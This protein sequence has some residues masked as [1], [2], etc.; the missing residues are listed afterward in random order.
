PRKSVSDCKSEGS[1]G[2]RPPVN[3]VVGL[4]EAYVVILIVRALLSWFP[5]RPGTPFEK[6]VRALDA[7]TEPVLR[8][9]RRLLPPVRV[10]G[11]GLDLSIIIVI[12]VAEIIVI[13]LLRA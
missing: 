4:I 1:G 8:P 11:M 7:V 5:V 10:G 13:P 2:P 6:L 12:L 3:I 9:I